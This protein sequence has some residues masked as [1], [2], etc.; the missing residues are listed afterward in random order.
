MAQPLQPQKSIRL[1]G[2]PT[3]FFQKT[4]GFAGEIYFDSDLDALRVYQGGSALE[5]K[6][7][8]DRA[9]VT[10][11]LFSRNYNDLTNKPSLFSGSYTDL[12]NKPALSAVALSGSYADL[13]DTPSI[14]NNTNQ[15]TNGAGFITNS[16]LS[17]YALTADIPTDTGDLTNGAGFITNSAL[18]SYATQSYVTSQG[19][20]TNSALSGLAT[21]SLVT[22]LLLSETIG[23]KTGAT[24]TV[25]HS[26]TTANVWAHS[27][28]AANFTVNVTNLP[29]TNNKVTNLVL[30]LTQGGTP[31]LPTAL[32]IGGAAQTIKWQDAG[33]PSGTAS[34]VDIVSFSLIRTFDAW[35]VI[36]S[37]STYG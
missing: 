11:Q 32:Q 36:G 3:T 35:T 34:Q 16:A 30:I 15:L 26:I 24:G 5:G 17:T 4:A 1:I 25:E 21:E 14:P 20:I 18:N 12:S 22:G 8:A 37:L 13:S 28:I 10:S 27:S 23:I 33:A 29:T 6:V 31:Y 7:V 2:R 9:W 19:Y